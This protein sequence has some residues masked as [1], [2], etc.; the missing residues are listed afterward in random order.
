MPTVIAYLYPRAYRVANGL[1]D[2]SRFEK[3]RHPRNFRLGTY[4]SILLRAIR[5]DALRKRLQQLQ[6]VEN[7]N[8]ISML[9]FVFSKTCLLTYHLM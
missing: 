7:K 3:A 8:Y 5:R 6:F 2:H 1:C 9:K 4:S